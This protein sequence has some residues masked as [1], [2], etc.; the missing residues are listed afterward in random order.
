MT[1]TAKVRSEILDTGHPRVKAARI[2]IDAPAPVIF[3]ILANPRRHSEIDGSSSVR[4]V[5]HGPE[6]LSLGAVFGM[7]MHLGINYRMTNTVVEFEEGRLIGWRHLGR[8]IWRYELETLP[9]GRTQVTETFDA[10]PTH[11]HPWLVLRKA[12]PFAQMAVAKT[13]VQLK[14][15][16]ERDAATA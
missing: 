8:W 3:E 5:L 16:A 9:D 7:A 12:Y 6:R 1:D 4:H 14:A 15:V 10:R 13:L 2:V 11:L